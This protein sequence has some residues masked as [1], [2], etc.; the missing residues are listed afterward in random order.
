MIPLFSSALV[1]EDIFEA[2]K[3]L[4]TFRLLDLVAVKGKTEGINVYELIGKKGETPEMSA[5]LT[6]YEQA[7]DSYRGR[8]FTEAMNLLKDQ[9]SDGPSHT[10][11]TRCASLLQNPPPASWNGIYI[12][13]IK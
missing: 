7:L 2:A 12:S 9:L 3:E 5:I 10:L 6:K 8:R 11:H 4:F 1:S 13:T